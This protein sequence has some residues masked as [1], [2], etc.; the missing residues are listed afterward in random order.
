[1]GKGRLELLAQ[2]AGG[3]PRARP[4]P[5]LPSGS[6]IRVAFLILNLG[7]CSLN[8]KRLNSF[9]LVHYTLLNGYTIIYATNPH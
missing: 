3:G 2:G 1:M 7:E 4:G 8:V 6:S 5:Q 9:L